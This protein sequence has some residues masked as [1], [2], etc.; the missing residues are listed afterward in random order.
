VKETYAMLNVAFSDVAWSQS[1]TYEWYLYLKV[2][3]K[4]HGVTLAIWKG[5]M[6][7]KINL[8]SLDF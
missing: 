7:N 2:I 8:V 6:F 1:A 5:L 4:C 3:K